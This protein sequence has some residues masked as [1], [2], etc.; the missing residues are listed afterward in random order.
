MRLSRIV[1]LCC[2]AVI[3]A[4]TTAPRLYSQQTIV[5]LP[6]ADQTQAGH[7]FALHE[8]QLRLWEPETFWTSTNFLTYGVSET[9]EVCLTTYNIDLAGT[10]PFKPY[11]ALGFGY[12]MAQPLFATALRDAGM[13]YLEP[14]LTLGQMV[15]V[16]LDGLGTGLWSYG[17]LSFRLPTL[18]TRLAGGLSMGSRQ[19]FGGESRQ[20]ISTDKISFIG[21]IEQPI[22]HDE[23]QEI[24]FA[25]EWFAG[26]HELADLVP[27]FVYHN[28]EHEFL[29]V[30][31]YKISNSSLNEGTPIG[32][33][34]A[35]KGNGIIFEIGKTF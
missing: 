1:L 24:G 19:I 12:K 32:T 30:L 5:N 4:L 14:K 25:M 34:I 17:H 2:G 11:T 35:R 29:V 20:F 9:F 3:I 18:Q 28:H 27:G 10:A 13:G 26:S 22:W 23:H 6:S 31:G 33:T 7:F 16:S 8:T 21:S 15:T